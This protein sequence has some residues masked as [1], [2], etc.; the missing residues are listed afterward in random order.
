MCVYIFY[1]IFLCLFNF[2]NDRSFG[3]TG[4]RVVPATSIIQGTTVVNA[5]DDDLTFSVEEG[6]KSLRAKKILEENLPTIDDGTPS[7]RHQQAMKSGPES[8]RIAQN[9]YVENVATEILRSV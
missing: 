9:G 4:S 5:T 2:P 8:I 3:L 6:Y 7:Y 1:I